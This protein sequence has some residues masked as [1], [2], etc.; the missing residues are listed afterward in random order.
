MINMNCLDHHNKVILHLLLQTYVPILVVP[1]TGQKLEKTTT[2][3]EL[4][5]TKAN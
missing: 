5:A 1:G 2:L 4:E 3:S